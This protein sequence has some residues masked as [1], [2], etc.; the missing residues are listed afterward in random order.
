MIMRTI[1]LILCLT[2]ILTAKQNANAEMRIK[3]GVLAI[4]SDVYSNDKNITSITIPNSVRYIGQK[5]FSYCTSLTKIVIPDSVQYIASGA[6]EGC[7]GLS[8]ISIP[9]SIMQIGKDAFKKCDSAQ[10]IVASKGIKNYLMDVHQI[11]LNNI[12]IDFKQFDNKLWNLYTE[13]IIKTNDNQMFPAIKLNGTREIGFAAFAVHEK[14]EYVVINSSKNPEIQAFAFADCPNLKC[15]EFFGLPGEL[16]DMAF[17]Y[18]NSSYIKNLQVIIHG[19]KNHST[20][21]QLTSAGIQEKNIVYINNLI[22]T[23]LG[24]RALG[25]EP[26]EYIKRSEFKD[27]NFVLVKL[28]DT[29][30]IGIAAFACNENLRNVTIISSN[31]PKIRAFAFGDCP[32]LETVEFFGIPGEITDNAFGEHQNNG[33]S[34]EYLDTNIIIHG[35]RDDSIHEQLLKAG[36]RDE[37]IIWAYQRSENSDRISGEAPA[38]YIKEGEFMGIRLESIE[39][40]DTREIGIGAF[41]CSENLKRVMIKSFYKPKIQAL[42]F[43]GCPKLKTIEFFGTPGEIADNAFGE[44]QN[45]LKTKIFIHGERDNYVDEQLGKAGIDPIN[46]T[47]ILD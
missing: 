30:E 1:S 18:H 9:N 45:T 40:A 29:H 32:N 33:E 5:A 44:H 31:K 46:I 24:A 34:P 20:H 25:Y 36:I 27:Q 22:K 10:F 4:S 42:A 15:I 19:E 41:K 12:L 38:E 14:L 21:K 47:Y 35:E 28:R 8:Q 23:Q 17:G 26:A 43:D 7:T 16:D 13:Y 11:P 3:H 6:F 37:N 39:L 2:A